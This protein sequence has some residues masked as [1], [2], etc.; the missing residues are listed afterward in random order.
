M[1]TKRTVNGRIPARVNKIGSLGHYFQGFIDPWW[2]KISCIHSML[3]IWGMIWVCFP[4]DFQEHL[5][6][7]YRV[8]L[9]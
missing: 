2:Y 1:K 7:I 6:K 4:Q 9:C 3:N 8:K 5:R